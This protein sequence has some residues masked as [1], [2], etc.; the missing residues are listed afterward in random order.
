MQIITI[1]DITFNISEI[2]NVYH[3]GSYCNIVIQTMKGEYI[4]NFGKDFDK[5][6]SEYNRIKK[7]INDKI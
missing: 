3:H 5:M 1:Q 7:I 6:F 4:F 2:E